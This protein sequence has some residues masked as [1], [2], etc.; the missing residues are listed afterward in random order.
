VLA[1]VLALLLRL[2][3]A[4]QQF[5]QQERQQ[6]LLLHLCQVSRLA[7]HSHCL[8]W[9]LPVLWDLMLLSQLQ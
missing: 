3:V 7:L 9:Q 2:A 1:A 4:Q 8:R 6:L 5:E